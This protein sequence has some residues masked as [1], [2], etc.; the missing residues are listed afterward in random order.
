MKVKTNVK[1]GKLAGNHNQ[2]AAHGLKVKTGV[3]VGQGT[4][5]GPKGPP[6]GPNGLVSETQT[7]QFEA[8]E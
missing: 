6:I 1:A 5:G 7:G 4:V 2:T 8:S 3:K